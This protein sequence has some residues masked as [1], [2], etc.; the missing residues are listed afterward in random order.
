MLSS[1]LQIAIERLKLGEWR[2]RVDVEYPVLIVAH[3][4]LS[5]KLSVSDGKKILDSSKLEW[6][7]YLATKG[8]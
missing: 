3:D 5:G 8:W 2:P 6:E 4:V 1:K 7:K